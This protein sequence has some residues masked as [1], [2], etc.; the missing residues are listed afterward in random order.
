MNIV[1]IAGS[2]IALAA[3]AGAANAAGAPGQLYNKTISVSFRVT[4]N[5][6]DE[7]GKG[8]G[9]GREISQTIYISNQGRVFLRGEHRGGSFGKTVH[10][11]PEV[12]SGEFRFEGNQ[13]V[14]PH[15]GDLSSGAANETISFDPGFQSCTASMQFG[16]EPGKVYKWKSLDGRNITASVMNVSTPTCSIREGNAFAQ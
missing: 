11:G 2:C 14:R 9:N 6:V 15:V 7:H 1:K 12:S 3:M 8:T 5:G 16:H 4:N 10:N 13:L